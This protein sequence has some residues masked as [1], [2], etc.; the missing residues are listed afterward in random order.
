MNIEVLERL[1]Q[2]INDSLS[3]IKDLRNEKNKAQITHSNE[4][5]IPPEKVNVMKSKL[6]E[7]VH[8]LDDLDV[9]LKTEKSS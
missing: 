2:R 5:K 8:W 1:E 9:V 7:I 3:V 6:Q 4:S